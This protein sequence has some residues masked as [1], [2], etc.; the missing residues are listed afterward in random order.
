MKPL[1]AFLPTPAA[2]APDV[3]GRGECRDCG[4]GR[5]VPPSADPY[6]RGVPLYQ[7]PRA[8]GIGSAQRVVCAE[9]VGRSNR[10]H[11]N[12]VRHAVRDLKAAADRGIPEDERDAFEA[13][14]RLIGP[15]Q[16][17]TTAQGIRE[18]LDAAPAKGRRDR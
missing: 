4:A 2:D 3:P 8:E 18:K 5:D 6:A 7:R 15:A 9:C 11:A 17:N 14:S 13:L 1:A 12:S 16:A 10:D